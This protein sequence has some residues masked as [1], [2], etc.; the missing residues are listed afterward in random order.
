MGGG[1]MESEESAGSAIRAFGGIMRLS[2]VL[3][4]CWAVTQCALRPIP[5]DLAVYVNRDVD[6]IAGLEELALRRYAGMTGDNY[7]SDQA[8]RRAL[9]TQVIPVYERFSVLADGIR[10]R[11]EP[12]R[13]LHA[14]YRQAATLRLRGFRMILLAIDTR[15]PDLVRQANRLLEQARQLIVQWRDRLD[16]MAEAYELRRY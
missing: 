11:T 7:V 13:R 5:R 12:V 16:R 4:C 8:L 3:L 10:P 2:M 15:D 14:L 6:G 1:R 9:E